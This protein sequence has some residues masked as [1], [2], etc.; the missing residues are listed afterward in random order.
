MLEIYIWEH[1]M[2]I[3]TTYYTDLFHMLARR[4]EDAKGMCGS[5]CFHLLKKKE[6]ETR[7]PKAEMHKCSMVEMQQLHRKISA[8]FTIRFP[9]PR[10]GRTVIPLV[11][12]VKEL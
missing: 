3:F 10:Q 1:N 11:G 7:R 12:F 4:R 9:L 5:C 2:N 6:M 8:A